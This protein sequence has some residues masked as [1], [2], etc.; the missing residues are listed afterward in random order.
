MLGGKIAEFMASI[1]FEADEKSLKTSLTQVAA[2]GAAITAI[3]GGIYAGIIKVAQGEAEMAITA[4]RL[5]TTADRIA[6][7]GYV[8]EQSGASIDAV[9]SSMEGMIAN[10]PRIKDAA[11]ALEMAGERMRGMSEAQ[12]R[13]YAA[14][15]GIDQSLIP[16]LTGDVAAL[17]D[18][19]RQMYA[20]AGIDAKAAA[21][22]SK[23]FMAELGKLRTMAVLL[24]KGVALA[25]IGKMR[26][27]IEH[28]RRVI[29]ENFDKIKRLFEAVITV[30]LRIA[31]VFGAFVYR[32]IKL[33][34]QAVA[35]FDKLDEGTRNLILG[36]FGL[37]AAWKVLN[38]G[39]LATPVGMLITGLLGIIALVDDLM[40]YMEGGESFFDWGPW[41]GQIKAVVEGL[42]PLLAALGKLAERVLPLISA[43]LSRIWSF[44]NEMAATVGKTILD[45][46]GGG[47]GGAAA[48][49]DTLGDAI[50]QIASIIGAVFSVTAPMAVDIFTF[51]L[52][53]IVDYLRMLMQVATSIAHA[54]VALFTGDLTGAADA[55][56]DAL[57]AVWDFLG[58]IVGRVKDLVG[59]VGG[60]LLGVLGIDVGTNGDA[61]RAAAQTNT[62]ALVPSHSETASYDNSKR[63]TEVT[64]TTS[65]TIT[66]AGDPA[67]VGNNVAQRQQQVNADLV[68]HTRGVAR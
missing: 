4:Q 25:F 56:L 49:V 22:A 65:I 10:N 27:D 5:G 24:A 19:F 9:T 13:A 63:S 7:L 21:E 55:F 39:F 12:R 42:A 68:R 45:A 48:F 35:W 52:G 20:V 62:A 44:I 60:K 36:A 40:T 23:G 64:S 58:S 11:K 37:L 43:A 29:M 30:V 15:M 17:K 26:R 14:R 8:A 41:V 61:V 46:F 16:A 57:R 54:F 3:A 66:G 47:F 2:F 32:V 51:A 18:E 6:E 33:A 38:M 34:S 67:A 31:A 53:G 59:G 28:L 1:G 50:E